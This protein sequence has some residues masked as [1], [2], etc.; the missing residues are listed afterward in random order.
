MGEIVNLRRARKTRD[1]RVKEDAA[2]GNRVAYGRTKVERELSAAQARFE[3][4]SSTRISASAKRMAARER[5]ADLLRT[6]SSRH[7]IV[8]A[9]H[10]TSVS[11]EDA[12][13]RALKDI[14]AQ[15]GV[16]ARG[17]R[18]ESRCGTWRSKSLLGAARF[19][20]GTG[21]GSAPS[22]RGGGSDCEAGRGGV[23]TTHSACHPSRSPAASDLPPRK[24]DVSDLRF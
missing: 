3:P 19:R 22:P 6:R 23:E 12:F 13:W 16:V 20:A 18:R 21:V 9:G 1:K 2:Q 4:P 8:I 11:L 15:E 14:A 5:G 10:R 24:A 7:S 17:A